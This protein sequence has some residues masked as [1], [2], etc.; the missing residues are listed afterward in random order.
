[1][2]EIIA[3]VL[4]L[5][6]Q[7]TSLTGENLTLRA[8]R[9]A[10]EQDLDRAIADYERE[11]CRSGNLATENA[12]LKAKLAEIRGAASKLTCSVGRHHTRD[13]YEECSECGGTGYE[14]IRHRKHCAYV[15]LNSLLD[16][17]PKEGE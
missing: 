14:H 5:R 4:Q 12:A 3:E 10:L 1:M 15:H 9:D 6:D 13:E 2:S 16:D 11:W 17:A 7:V 8:E